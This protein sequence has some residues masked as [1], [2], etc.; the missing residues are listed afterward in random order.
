MLVL[1][2]G[3]DDIAVSV[4]AGATV[5]FDARDA[6]GGERVLADETLSI[7]GPTAVLVAFEHLDGSA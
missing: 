5:V 6:A 1:H 3:A 4:P 2:F 7:S